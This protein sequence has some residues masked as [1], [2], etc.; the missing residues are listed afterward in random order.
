MIKIDEK[1]INKIARD[2]KIYLEQRREQ[3]KATL[4]DLRLLAIAEFT[5]NFEPMKKTKLYNLHSGEYCEA[6]GYFY[7]V[8]K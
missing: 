3:S 8:L 2:C 4:K 6:L 7:D 5:N 1:K